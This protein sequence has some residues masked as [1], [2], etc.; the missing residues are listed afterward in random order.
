MKIEITKNVKNHRVNPDYP[1]LRVRWGLGDT[2]FMVDDLGPN[3]CPRDREVLDLV[4]DL[5]LL[6]PSFYREL[7]RIVVILKGVKE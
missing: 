6:S 3:W 7:V 2:N 1:T 4:Q 5:L